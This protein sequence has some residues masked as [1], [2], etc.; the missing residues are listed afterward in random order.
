MKIIQDNNFN[1]IFKIKKFKM[2]KKVYLFI[3]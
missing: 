3:K 1:K 2:K